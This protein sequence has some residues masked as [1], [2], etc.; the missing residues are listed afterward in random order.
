MDDGI[1]CLST[2]L[3]G[4]RTA[5]VSFEVFNTQK[6]NIHTVLKVMNY[7]KKTVIAAPNEDS[8]PAISDEILAHHCF[9]RVRQI[10]S[11]PRALVR[12]QRVIRTEN[13]EPDLLTGTQA[14]VNQEPIQPP[15]GVFVVIKAV[16]LSEP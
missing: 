2:L 14:L 1:E 6:Q 7:L 3:I 5:D 4:S 16:V 10:S 8:S 13:K 9:L 11:C 12:G 15:T